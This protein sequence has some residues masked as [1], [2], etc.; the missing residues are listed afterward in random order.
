MNLGRSTNIGPTREAEDPNMKS[1]LPI[2]LKYVH[3]CTLH[4]EVRIIEKLIY[5][6]ILL[7]WNHKP[8]SVA[9]AAIRRLEIV[10]SNAGLHKGNVTIEKSDRLSGKKG[11]VPNKPSIG[12]AKARRFL[13]NHTCK[14]SS[15]RY[16][17][18][19][20]IVQATRT[21][22]GSNRVEKGQVWTNLDKLIGVIRKENLSSEDMRTLQNHCTTFVK[23]VHD[24]WGKDN[25]THYMVLIYIIIWYFSHSG[26]YFFLLM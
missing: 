18:W 13:S 26:L 23:S 11:N 6:H 22:E 5:L 4:A 3:I 25:V 1:V 21:L 20:E 8:E 17:I 24:C 12:G 16:E 14:E 9:K 19:R 7:A 15:V 10:L 2:P